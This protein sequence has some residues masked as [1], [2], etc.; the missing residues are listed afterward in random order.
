M[1]RIALVL[2]LFAPSLAFAE[3]ELDPRI[4]LELAKAKRLREA[5]AVVVQPV[6]PV[7]KPSLNIDPSHT[8]AKCGTYANVVKEEANG[9]HSHQCPNCGNTW[10]HAN[11][12]PAASF[13]L[14]ASG[15]PGGNCPGATTKARWRLFK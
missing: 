15:C 6:T 10:W 12:A 14:P 11:P 7:V 13:T 4:L 2:C 3:T 1:F 5:A 8:C 9:M